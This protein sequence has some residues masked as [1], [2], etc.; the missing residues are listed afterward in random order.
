MDLA[1]VLENVFLTSYSIQVDPDPASILRSCAFREQA[2]HV[3]DNDIFRLR[4]TVPITLWDVTESIFLK[5]EPSR[6]AR[7][8]M[9]LAMGFSGLL[10]DETID[11]VVLCDF[12]GGFTEMQ[13]IRSEIPTSRS[14]L[15][16][17]RQPQV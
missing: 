14:K 7:Y 9:V 3:P 10:G 4:A 5:P 12:S 15:D 6:W 1:W 2:I 8:P 17:S 13:A 16:I 11:L